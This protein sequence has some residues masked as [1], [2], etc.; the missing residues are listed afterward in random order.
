[1]LLDAR[2]CVCMCVFYEWS[3]MRNR[4]FGNGIFRFPLSETIHKI[5][6]DSGIYFL[7]WVSPKRDPDS[8]NIQIARADLISSISYMFSPSCFLYPKIHIWDA[9][10]KLTW[11]PNWPK[12]L[13]SVYK[14][15]VFSNSIHCRFRGRDWQCSSEMK[16]KVIYSQNRLRIIKSL[17]I[18]CEH[19]VGKSLK[20]CIVLLFGV[21]FFM[22]ICITEMMRKY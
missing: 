1:M 14:N 17:V 8:K 7:N 16:N 22:S 5:M 20:I 6:C 12:S 15:N 19:S 4:N 18:F 13:N 21:G 3:I 11:H 10:T 9:A 2:S